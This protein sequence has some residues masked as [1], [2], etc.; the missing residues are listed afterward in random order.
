MVEGGIRSGKAGVDFFRSLPRLDVRAMTTANKVTIARI[1]LV[2]FFV[3]QVLYYVEAGAEIHRLLA[4]LSFAVASISDGIDGYIARR[5]NQ[6]SELGA[7]L[8]PLADKLLLVSAVVMLSFDHAPHLPRLPLWLTVTVLSRDVLLAIG[9]WVIQHTCGKTVVRP[10]LLGKAATVMQMTCVLW[11]LLKWPSN[12]L[13]VWLVLAAA[14]TAFS[15]V[16]YVIDG[17]GQLSASPKSTASP[18]Q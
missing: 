10:S 4:V 14:L 2:P 15:G 13:F 8:D 6:R 1:L 18:R 17:V 5:Y 7:F 16:F 11:A 12:W 3:M 9:T